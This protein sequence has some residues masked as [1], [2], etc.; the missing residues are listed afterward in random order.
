MH[1]CC[2]RYAAA[3][4]LRLR[5]RRY[6]AAANAL[7]CRRCAAYGLRCRRCAAAV[8]DAAAALP[9]LRCQSL[10]I[11][12]CA[13]AANALHCRRCAAYGL[14]CRRWPLRC[15]RRAKK[16]IAKQR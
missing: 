4:N 8:N 14:R 11:R 16:K 6:A 15:R 2:R 10:R 1:C 13:A 5:L 12:R 9:P 7:H 3:S